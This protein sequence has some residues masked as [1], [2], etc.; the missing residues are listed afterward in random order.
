MYSWVKNITFT[1]KCCPTDGAYTSKVTHVPNKEGPNSFL[2]IFGIKYFEVKKKKRKDR[3]GFLLLPAPLLRGNSSPFWTDGK[4][5]TT[6]IISVDCIWWND[7]S[8][9]K[10]SANSTIKSKKGPEI[11]TLLCTLLWDRWTTIQ[12]RV[13]WPFTL[14]Y[15]AE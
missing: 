8:E 7:G 6:D 12:V 1:G 9:G 11:S 5:Y 15:K 2:S 3:G 10:W 4:I 13:R 14:P